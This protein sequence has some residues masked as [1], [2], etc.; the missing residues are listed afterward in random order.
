MG[1]LVWDEPEK[2]MPIEDWKE[3]SA[4]GA[5]PGVYTLNMS[6]EDAMKWRAKLTGTKRG[7]PQVE[8]RKRCEVDG[9]LALI[10]VS[11]GDGITKPGS[12]VKREK[13]RF[14]E[15]TKEHKIRVAISLNGTFC[16]TEN[17]WDELVMGIDEA[18]HILWRLGE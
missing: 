10:I 13:D 4:D 6:G 17:D 1:I 14:R 3:L 7:N 8:I 16:M 11:L 5:P 18:T 2:A 9:A 15:L 12:W